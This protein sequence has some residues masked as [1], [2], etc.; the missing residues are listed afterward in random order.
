MNGMYNV[1]YIVSSFIVY[2]VSLSSAAS[3][4]VAADNALDR[5]RLSVC[6]HFLY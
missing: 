2:D 6:N 4:G 3:R 5:I 1:D